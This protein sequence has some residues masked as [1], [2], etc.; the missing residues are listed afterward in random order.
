[1][2]KSILKEKKK[3]K[4]KRKRDG[5]PIRGSKYRGVSQN[6]IGWQALMMFKN[7]RPYIGTY[8]SEEIA[9]RVYD[10]VSIKRRGIKSKTNFY[11]SNEQINKILS[12]NI[13]YKDPNISKV[14]SKLID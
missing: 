10:I 2:N 5:K 7:N 1:M 3:N 9:A 11:Y 6:G 4:I 12:A 8:Y 14:V 13:D